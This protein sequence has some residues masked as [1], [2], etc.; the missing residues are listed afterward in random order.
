[1][2]EVKALLSL[3]L[4]SYVSSVNPHIR[5][6]ACVWLLALVTRCGDEPDVQSRIM[7]IQDA[8]ISMLSDGDGTCQILTLSFN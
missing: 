2:T 6:A 8:F 4:E 3:L 7:N 5:Q 1:M